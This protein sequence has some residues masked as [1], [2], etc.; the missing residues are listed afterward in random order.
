MRIGWIDSWRGILI[1]LVVIG[2]VVGMSYHFVNI[3]DQRVLS[4]IYKFI[5][6]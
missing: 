4:L 6:N 3:E 1:F 2:H 5:Y